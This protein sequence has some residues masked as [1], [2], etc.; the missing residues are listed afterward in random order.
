MMQKVSILTLIKELLTMTKK[1]KTNKQESIIGLL[2]KSM[3]L[4]QPYDYSE[5]RMMTVPFG[6]KEGTVT[7][8]LTKAK[9]AGLIDHNHST[10]I[11]TRLGKITFAAI[12]EFDR[13]HY[14]QTS[15]T[16]GVTQKTCDKVKALE[17]AGFNVNEVMSIL[18]LN[19]DVITDIADCKWNVR[20]YNDLFRS[21]VEAEKA[22]SREEPED[23]V[24]KL[25]PGDAL[26]VANLEALNEALSATISSF[27]KNVEQEL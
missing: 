8:V 12:K 6:F 10:G 2:N 11:R 13:S 25:R 18:N 17:Q 16:F 26:I 27:K 3:S 5:I 7:S 21:R 4:N 22:E 23:W 24:P 1:A 19:S 20:K 14:T 15:N 9:G